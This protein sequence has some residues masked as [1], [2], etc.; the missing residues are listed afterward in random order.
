MR[1]AEYG[2][3]PRLGDQPQAGAERARCGAPGE[4]SAAAQAATTRVTRPLSGPY[5]AGVIREISA[6][7]EPLPGASDDHFEAG[8]ESRKR[9]HWPAADVN[10]DVLFVG[11]GVGIVG[12]GRQLDIA[13]ELDEIA[14][15][16]AE[17]NYALTGI[18]ARAPVVVAVVTADGFGQAERRTVVVDCAGL[19]VV[20]SQN[21]A[22]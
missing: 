14:C 1:I 8:P 11:H 6:R 12:G 2:Q 13:E 3:E 17:N 19:A 9:C 22:A 5:L 10:R 20:A 18:V 15:L 21:C 4:R 16:L 7:H